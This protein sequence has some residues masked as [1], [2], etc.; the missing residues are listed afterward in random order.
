MNKLQ[1]FNSIFSKHQGKL[2]EV[3]LVSFTIL[4]HVQIKTNH[5]NK[6]ASTLLNLPKVLNPK[7]P[8]GRGGAS[9]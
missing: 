6:N 3:L 1:A 9:P 7:S 5:R 4:I 8:T 2:D